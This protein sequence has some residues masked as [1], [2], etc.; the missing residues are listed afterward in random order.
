MDIQKLIGTNIRNLRT[1][2]SI[3]QEELAARMNV[4]QAYVS[5]LEAGQLNPTITTLEQI[6]AALEVEPKILLETHK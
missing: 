5:R 1:V 4:D 3:S 2:A 6:A